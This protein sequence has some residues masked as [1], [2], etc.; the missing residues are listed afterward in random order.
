MFCLYMTSQIF[1]RNDIRKTA[2]TNVTE[3]IRIEDDRL[4]LQ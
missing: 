3:F 4:C 1:H 2:W